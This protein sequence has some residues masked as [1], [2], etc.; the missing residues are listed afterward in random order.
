M[1]FQAQDLSRSDLTN[2]GGTFV[3]AIRE[4]VLAGHSM[5]PSVLPVRQCHSSAYLR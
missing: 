4:A 3:W 5:A 1:P 2:V